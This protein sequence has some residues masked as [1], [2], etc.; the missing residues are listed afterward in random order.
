MGGWEGI[1]EWLGRALSYLAVM[2]SSMG[3]MTLISAAAPGFLRRERTA[4]RRG[5]R[6]C[7]LWGAVF[8]VNCVLIAAL[9]ALLDGVVGTVLALVVMVGLLVVSLAG[10]AAVSCEV[11]RRVLA[12]GEKNDG[13]VLTQLLTGTAVIFITAVIPVFGWLVFTGGLLVGIG[14][15]LDTAVEDYRPTRRPATAGAHEAAHTSS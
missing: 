13:S 1:G 15:F 3:A 14:A 8:V 6:R 5:L 11:G 2:V 4:A 10:L 7:F 12:L 9:L